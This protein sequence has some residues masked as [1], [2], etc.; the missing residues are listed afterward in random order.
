MKDPEKLFR[1]LSDRTRLRVLCLLRTY[2]EVCVCDL[3]EAL[4]CPQPKISRHLAVLRETGLVAD[5]RDAQWVHYRIR[6]GLEPWVRRVLEETL[7]E[8]R[9]RPPYRTDAKR[10]AGRNAGRREAC[11]V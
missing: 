11:G 7:A 2:G 9:E 1:A 5:R 6:P 10:I 4:R 8:V 3:T